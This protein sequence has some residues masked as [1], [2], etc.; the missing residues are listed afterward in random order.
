MNTLTINAMTAGVLLFSGLSGFSY[1]ATAVDSNSQILVSGMDN[2]SDPVAA[3]P[4]MGA[5]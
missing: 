4:Q 3:R 1:A 5:M 2:L